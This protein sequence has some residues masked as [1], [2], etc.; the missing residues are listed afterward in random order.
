MYVILAGYVNPLVSHSNMKE[1]LESQMQWKF[2]HI[3]FI[4]CD[5]LI[6]I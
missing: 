2:K 5:S 3:E 4:A 6:I 1:T